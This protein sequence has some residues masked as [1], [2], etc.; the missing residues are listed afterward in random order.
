MRRVTIIGKFNRKNKSEEVEEIIAEDV[1]KKEEV[2]KDMGDEL[3]KGEITKTTMWAEKPVPPDP[4]SLS[5]IVVGDIPNKE[6]LFY[7]LP[8][9]NHRC[10]IGGTWYYFVKDVKQKEIGRAHV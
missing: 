4:K 8:M 7:V 3:R 2:G 6:Q 10:H 1:L 5:E 9:K